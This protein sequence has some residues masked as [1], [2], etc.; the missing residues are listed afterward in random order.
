MTN[1]SSKATKE[2]HKPI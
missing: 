2:M 1:C